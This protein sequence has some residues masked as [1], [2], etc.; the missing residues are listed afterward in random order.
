[1]SVQPSYRPFV[2]PLENRELLT[3]G[4]QAYV[5]GLTLYV[6]GTA[7]ND[8]INVTESNNQIA[9]PG[10]GIAVNGKNVNSVNAS[11]VSQVIVYGNGGNNSVDLST[12][13]TA[14]TIYCG[15]GANTV[16]CGTDSDTVNS[17]GG[18]DLVY[19]PFVP[20]EP[21]SNGTAITDIHQGQNPL[22]QTDAALAEA[23]NDGF[24]FNSVIHYQGN[25]IYDVTLGGKTP[26]QKVFFNGWTND[27][28]PVMEKGVFWTVLMQRAR[29]AIP[30]HQHERRTD[31]R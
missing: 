23:V 19:R 5:S 8:I 4:I 21:I 9:V 11:A 13:K 20:T 25:D 15:S 22:C 29:S 26:M 30:R 24:N 7:G 6:M 18:S 31:H 14:A 17:G 3:T 16:V 1:M 2:E 12:L 10:S 27:N 28:D